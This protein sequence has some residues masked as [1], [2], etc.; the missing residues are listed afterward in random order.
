MAKNGNTGEKVWSGEEEQV[1][2]YQ[3]EP[4]ENRDWEG[5]LITSKAQIGKSNEGFI[6]YVKGIQIRLD[7]SAKEEGQKD[8]SVFL[9][10]FTSLKPGKD[11]VKMPNRAGQVVD[12]GKALGN[13]YRG[14]VVTVR[15]PDGEESVE[16]LAV[17][18]LLDW[19]KNQDGKR[20]KLHTKTER[21]QN[22]NLQSKVDYFIEAEQGSSFE[23]GEA[24]EEMEE[25]TE[26]VEEQD[27]EEAPEEEE[28]SPI[29]PPK[30]KGKK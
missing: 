7:G 6:P 29:P 24:E 17:K 18:P 13:P 26:E 3:F 8:R 14:P 19:V 9:M 20:V 25:E 15:S 27:T 2:R 30:K 12:L 28:E 16:A 21:D 4:V 23:D 22:G 5:T 11:G 10:L 1:T